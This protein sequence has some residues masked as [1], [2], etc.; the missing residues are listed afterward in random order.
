MKGGIYI[1]AHAIRRAKERY[2]IELTFD[3]LRYILNEI[4][5]GN[6]KEL[7][8]PRNVYGVET[9]GDAYHIRYKGVLL[10]PVVYQNIIITF[11]PVGKRVS[12][13]KAMEAK[14]S[15]DYKQ[16]MKRRKLN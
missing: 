2:G 15:K 12:W 11:R 3:D 16:A 6:T 13:N 5:E 7:K 10:E 4:L 14:S 8:K 9:K 1:T